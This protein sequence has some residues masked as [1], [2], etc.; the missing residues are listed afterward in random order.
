[1]KFISLDSLGN[2]SFLPA[3]KRRVFLAFRSIIVGQN[4]QLRKAKKVREVVQQHQSS[5]GPLLRDYGLNR[6]VDIIKALLE[7]RIFESELKAKI[8]FPELFQLSPARDVQ[9]TASENNAARSEAEALEEI[10]SLEGKDDK[11]NEDCQDEDAV[12]GKTPI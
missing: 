3:E 7:D 4:A 9:R 1:V 2:M 10:A 5:F 8:A 6:V 11:E 12:D